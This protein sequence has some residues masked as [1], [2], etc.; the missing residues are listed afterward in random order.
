MHSLHFVQRKHQNKP[1]TTI[2]PRVEISYLALGSE[3]EAHT[4]IRTSVLSQPTM[5]LRHRRS[6]R[7]VRQAIP[8]VTA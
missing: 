2:Q 7:K 1:N 6:I 3:P 8:E 4:H 5:Y